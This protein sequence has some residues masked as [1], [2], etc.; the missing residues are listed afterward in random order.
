MIISKSDLVL[1]LFIINALVAITSDLDLGG[2]LHM[3]YIRAGLM[4]VIL[5]LLIRSIKWNKTTISIIITLLYLLFVLST[6]THFWSNFSTYVGV[7]LSL[8]MYPLC[9][10]YLYK[11]EHLEKLSKIIVWLLLIFGLQFIIFNSI[12]VGRYAY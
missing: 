12:G 9:F 11:Q 4:I 6:N 10:T 3:G 2:G 5:P 7:A 1:F 8:L